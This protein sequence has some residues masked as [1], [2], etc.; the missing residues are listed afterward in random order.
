MKI[1]LHISQIV[2][3]GTSL[4]RREREHLAAALEQ[5]LTRQLRQRA[6]GERGAQAAAAR[7]CPQAPSGSDLGARIAREVLA[8][9]PAGILAGGRPARVLPPARR[10]PGPAAPGAGR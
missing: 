7:H 10:Q 1:N 4:T 5:E 3:D 2:V 8:A 9:L 6:V